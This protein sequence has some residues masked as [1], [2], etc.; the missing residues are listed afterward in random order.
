M[1]R[2]IKL[3][4]E[5]E[6]S[7]EPEE[8]TEEE[9]QQIVEAAEKP[10]SKYDKHFEKEYRPAELPPPPPDEPLPEATEEDFVEVEE[11]KPPEKPIINRTIIILSAVG[12]LLTLG[13]LG[14]MAYKFLGRPATEKKEIETKPPKTIIKKTTHYVETPKKDDKGRTIKK[15]EET[16]E[17]QEPEKEATEPDKDK[18]IDKK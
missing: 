9:Y 3:T 11:D 17:T 12:T 5:N 2:C 10:F 4:E 8:L 7:T 6:E 1:K 18:D 16:E 13:I 15:T 14:I